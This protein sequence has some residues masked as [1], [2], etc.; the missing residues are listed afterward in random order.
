MI[1]IIIIIIRS[2][3]VI[4]SSSSSSISI[5]ISSSS[6]FII[7]ITIIIIIINIIIIILGRVFILPRSC[8]LLHYVM[9][10]YHPWSF[11]YSIIPC[12]KISR[13]LAIF[14]DAFSWMK[15]VVFWLK[16]HWRF[17]KWTITQHWFRKWFGVV[18]ATSHFLNQC[19][20]HS[21]RHICGTLGKW[22][23]QEMSKVCKFERIRLHSPSHTKAP[24]SNMDCH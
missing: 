19:W 1:I 24:F 10:Q 6:I 9:Y 12:K 18:K 5:I 20:P 22:G 14:S 2:I 4:S 15:N 7:T 17:F 16:F 21:L 11:S 23:I 8:K 13:L 3:I